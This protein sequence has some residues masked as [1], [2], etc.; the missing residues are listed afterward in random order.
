MAVGLEEGFVDETIEL[1]FELELRIHDT[2]NDGGGGT[3]PI[4]L[5]TVEVD[6]VGPAAAVD[7]GVWKGCALNSGRLEASSQAGGTIENGCKD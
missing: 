5:D 3:M 2:D 1:E 7:V 4:V 6:V